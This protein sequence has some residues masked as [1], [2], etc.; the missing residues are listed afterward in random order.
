M[1]KGPGAENNYNSHLS[2]EYTNTDAAKHILSNLCIVYP[3]K[4]IKIEYG[5]IYPV[6]Q[7]SHVFEAFSA[8]CPI[9]LSLSSPKLVNSG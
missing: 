4:K 5:S 7:T 2:W 1:A 8:I 9:K 6:M 3:K